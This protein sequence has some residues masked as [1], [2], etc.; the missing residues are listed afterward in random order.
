MKY[1][2]L[3]KQFA[4]FV[5]IISVSMYTVSVCLNPFRYTTHFF[6]KNKF[7]VSMQLTKLRKLPTQFACAMSRTTQSRFD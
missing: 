1:N 2:C 5:M 3:S 6:L 4:N 7:T